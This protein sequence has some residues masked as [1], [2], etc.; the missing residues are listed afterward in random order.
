M[1]ASSETEVVSSQLRDGS[2]AVAL[3]GASG[4]ARALMSREPV[5]AG[6][7]ARRGAYSA[8]IGYL[9]SLVLPEYIES[10]G[11]RSATLA[12]VSYFGTE[13]ADALPDFGRRAVAMIKAKAEGTLAGALG[14]KTTKRKGG[15]RNAKRKPGRR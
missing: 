1:S 3:G 13:I 8:F 2:V 15:S 10:P 12:L 9:V 11:L 6:W 14:S 7:I 5:S 4:V